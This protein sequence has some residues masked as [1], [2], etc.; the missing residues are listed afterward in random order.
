MP[1]FLPV[2]ADRRLE[3]SQLQLLGAKMM[4]LYDRKRLL[5]TW[6]GWKWLFRP[7]YSSQLGA[8]AILLLGFQIAWRD[9]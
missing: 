1:A 9:R 4:V 7:L 8:K 2:H 5:I 6:E 3:P